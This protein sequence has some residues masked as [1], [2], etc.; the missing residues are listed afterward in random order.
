[1]SENM[2][3]QT[4]FQRFTRSR[5]IGDLVDGRV[6]RALPFGAF[7]EVDG[8]DGFY[9]T[10]Q[11]PTVGTAV[12]VRVAAIDPVKERFAVEAP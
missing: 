5:S 4:P 12:R 11:P 3:E 10:E 6:V 2:S 7:V 8:V 9:R 1:M